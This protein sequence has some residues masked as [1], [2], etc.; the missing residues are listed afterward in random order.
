MSSLLDSLSTFGEDRELV[1]HQYDRHKVEF[2]FEDLFPSSYFA[3]KRIETHLGGALN[4]LFSKHW[5]ETRVHALG[6]CGTKLS[7][8]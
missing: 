3:M 8:P 2:A 5:N 6:S 4:I 1:Y 7:N